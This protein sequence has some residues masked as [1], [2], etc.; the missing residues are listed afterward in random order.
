MWLSCCFSLPLSSSTFFSNERQTTFSFKCHFG[1][2]ICDL[3][4]Y[5]LQFL[6]I[7]ILNISKILSHFIQDKVEI[8]E[9]FFGFSY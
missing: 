1:N 9:P 3:P 7:D 5:F 2:I 4:I 6:F 8:K